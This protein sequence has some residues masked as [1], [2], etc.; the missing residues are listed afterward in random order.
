MDITSRLVVNRAAMKMRAAE[1]VPLVERF[2]AAVEGR[3]A[4]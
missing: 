4:A 3:N 2:R 1:L